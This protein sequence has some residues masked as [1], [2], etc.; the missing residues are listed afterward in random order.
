[1]KT[2]ELRNKQSKSNLK[3]LWKSDSNEIIEIVQFLFKHQLFLII[4]QFSVFSWLKIRPTRTPIILIYVQ[5]FQGKGTWHVQCASVTMFSF[6][7]LCSIL[8][9]NPWSFK[10]QRADLSPINPFA[11]STI[12]DLNDPWEPQIHILQDTAETYFTLKTTA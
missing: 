5:S 9:L 6:S 7:F 11:A 2:V 4:Y 1:M 10:L 3:F 8:I 12:G